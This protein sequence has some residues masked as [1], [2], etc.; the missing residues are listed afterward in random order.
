MEFGKRL[1]EVRKEK[2]LSQDELAK[3]IGVHGAVIGRYERDEVKPSVD[4]ATKIA[5][6]LDISLDYL[7]GATSLKLDKTI[8]NKIQNIQELD[9]ENKGH[10]F[11][12]M[13]AFLL[14]CNIQNNLTS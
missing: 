14:K 3:M 9:N 7:V 11:A 2:K 13:D 6:A 4:M 1:M 10:L 8:I 12:L 5:N